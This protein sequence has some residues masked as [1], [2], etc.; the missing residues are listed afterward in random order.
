[1]SVISGYT[2]KTGVT[3]DDA[4]AMLHLPRST[5]SARPAA[6]SSRGID[7]VLSSFD[8]RVQHAL[9][10]LA[11]ERVELEV[12]KKAILER[13]SADAGSSDRVPEVLISLNS[14]IADNDANIRRLGGG[15]ASILLD[16]LKDP[17]L[18]S[19]LQL[20]V[21]TEDDAGEGSSAR[22]W[23]RQLDT[24]RPQANTGRSNVTHDSLTSTGDRTLTTG[25]GAPRDATLSYYQ[26]QQAKYGRGRRGSTS[27]AGERR[28]RGGGIDLIHPSIHP[29]HPHHYHLC[30]A[31]CILHRSLPAYPSR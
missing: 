26:K 29:F 14:K 23:R 11:I 6:R 1:M 5:A 18:A 4:A 21:P 22:V 17:A 16:A 7:A 10:Q 8:K 2:G 25:A 15:A 31:S 20:E 9:R 12:R 13:I 27:I 30:P 19:S 28:A 3:V 24:S